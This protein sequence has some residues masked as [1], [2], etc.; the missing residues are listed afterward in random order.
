MKSRVF[1][2]FLSLVL[3]MTAT[4]HA[5]DSYIKAYPSG[6]LRVNLTALIF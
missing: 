6:K 4:T 5:A 2:Y 1:F 3:V